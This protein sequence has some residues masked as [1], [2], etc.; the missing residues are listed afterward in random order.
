MKILPFPSKIK[1]AMVQLKNVFTAEKVN[2]KY[3][4]DGLEGKLFK[5]LAEKLNFEFEI[6]ESPNGQ[7]G[8][9]N[10]NGTW[11]GVI[12]LVQSG[13]ADMGFEALSISEER[14]K[15]IDFSATRIM[16]SRNL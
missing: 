15:V 5:C 3:V 14:L 9:N 8:S 1:V 13:K 4:L 10:N 7:Y 11:D 6:V 16:C 2:G 12:G